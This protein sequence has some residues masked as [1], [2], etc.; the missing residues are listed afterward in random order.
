MQ[1]DFEGIGQCRFARTGQ[2]GEPD[3]LAL[4]AV[5]FLA[6]FAADRE[7]LFMHVLRASQAVGDHAGGNRG[8]ADAIDQDEAAK[9]LR[10]L[11]AV[12]DHWFADGERTHADIVQQ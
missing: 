5:E 11:I 8:V 12:V 9:G 6:V 1:F 4:V 10:V 3:D 7:G 2:A